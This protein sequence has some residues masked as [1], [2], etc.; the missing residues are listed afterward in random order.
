MIS[1]NSLQSSYYFEG[2]Y[3]GETGHRS[4]ALKDKAVELR[5]RKYL[6]T[7]ISAKLNV[8]SDRV[9]KWCVEILGKEKAEEVSQELY[10]VAQGRNSE[11]KEERKIKISEL[12]ANDEKRK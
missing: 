9:A 2:V 8:S 3:L 5:L 1:L 10:S 6:L 12:I 7:D 11:E 4:Q